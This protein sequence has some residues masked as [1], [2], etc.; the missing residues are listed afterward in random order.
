MAKPYIVVVRQLGGIGD[1]IM[2]SCVYRG[3]KEAYPKHTICLATGRVY[4]CAALTDVASHNPFIDEVHIFEP[5]EATTQ[6]TKD[7][8]AKYYEGAPNIEE[9]LWYQKAALTVDLNT[10]CVDYEWEAM[11]SEGGIQKPRYQVWCEKAGVTPSTYFPVYNVTKDEKK[12]A[13]KF[14][15]DH[16]WDPR[17]CVLIGATACDKKR[18][19][20]VGK[21]EDLCAG[22]Q[23]MGLTPLIV[24]PLFNLPGYGAVNNKRVSDLM[25]IIALSRMVVSVDSGVL[26]MAGALRVPVIGLFGPTDAKMRMGMYEGSAIESRNLV[27]CA[28]CWYSYPC[29]GSV[30]QNEHFKCLNKVRPDTIL[31]EI[32]RWDAKIGG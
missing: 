22:V 13:V 25:P 19:V 1:V 9:E 16:G 12:Q 2:M 4:L 32:R 28:P 15:E 18:A 3:L 21:L 26:H 31:E 17:K 30:N 27:E 6:R 24:D 10:A 20:G 8:W 14:Y 29:L 7:V 5:W 11:H 23:S